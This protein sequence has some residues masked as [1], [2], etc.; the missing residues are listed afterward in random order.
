MPG[1]GTYLTVRIFTMFFFH[2][3]FGTISSSCLWQIH[4]IKPKEITPAR[5]KLFISVT[6]PAKA[7]TGNYLFS[8]LTYIRL[9]KV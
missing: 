8:F 2:Q 5:P 3:Q 9:L 1:S 6:P 7:Q 4:H